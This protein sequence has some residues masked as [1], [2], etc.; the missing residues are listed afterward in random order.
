MQ[1]DLS[2][3]NHLNLS[4]QLNKMFI[5]Q[6]NDTN[7]YLYYLHNITVQLSRANKNIFFIHN[8]PPRE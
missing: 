5:C 6:N 4:I 2:I 8:D 1:N 3:H 7:Y